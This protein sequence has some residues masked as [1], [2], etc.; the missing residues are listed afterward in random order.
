M[1]DPVN[2][3]GLFTPPIMLTPGLRLIGV[4]KLPN[5]QA[6]MKFATTGRSSNPIREVAVLITSGSEWVF[7][8]AYWDADTRL[9]KTYRGIHG[10]PDKDQLIDYIGG[11]PES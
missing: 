7:E 1:S 9:I 11:P 2:R 6:F 3:D 5:G 8:Y 4:G 10:D